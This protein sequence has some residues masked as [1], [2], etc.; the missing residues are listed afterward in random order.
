MVVLQKRSSF[1]KKSLTQMNRDLKIINIKLNQISSKQFMSFQSSKK[2]I[3]FAKLGTMCAQNMD[4][5]LNIELEWVRKIHWTYNE[6]TENTMNKLNEVKRENH[7][8]SPCGQNRAYIYQYHQQSKK[9][10][11]SYCG[12]WSQK[13]YDVD[14]VPRN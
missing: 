3:V 8:S 11:D 14:P 7:F 9:C 13:D 6:Y 2:S 4:T 5:T 1:Q 12:Y 10:A